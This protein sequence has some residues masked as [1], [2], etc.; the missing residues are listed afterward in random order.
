MAKARKPIKF[1]T[2]CQATGVVFDPR[3]LGERKCHVCHGK[4]EIK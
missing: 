1:C 4:G 3:L 2:T